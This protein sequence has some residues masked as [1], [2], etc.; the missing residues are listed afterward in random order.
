MSAFP[1]CSQFC[2]GAPLPMWLALTLAAEVSPF[3]PPAKRIQSPGFLGRPRP[4]E[5][6]FWRPRQSKPLAFT[7]GLPSRLLFLWA[8]PSSGEEVLWSSSTTQLHIHNWYTYM[9]YAEMRHM[10]RK[11]KL[12][13]KQID[14][15]SEIICRDG[16]ADQAKWRNFGQVVLVNSSW[17]RSHI[18]ALWK[19]S[20]PYN[21]WIQVVC[22]CK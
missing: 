5:L 7:N 1:G 16:C 11:D 14:F 13:S 17:T 4:S 12:V 18:V 8:P 21:S 10:Y 3:R 20:P 15:Q 2:L 6:L 19:V 9:C 22:F